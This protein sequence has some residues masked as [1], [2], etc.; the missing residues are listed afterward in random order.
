M[1][2]IVAENLA[3][4]AIRYAGH[5][6]TF[7]LSV[8]RAGE[9]AR[10]DRAPTT[11]SASTSATSPRLFERFYRADAARTS[12]GTGLGLAIVKHI[13]AAAGGE[14][15]ATAARP[16]PPHPLHVPGVNARRCACRAPFGRLSGAAYGVDRLQRLLGRDEHRLRDR[17]EEELR[18]VLRFWPCVSAQKTIFRS[19]A[20]CRRLL[21]DDHVGVGRRSGTRA[22]PT[23]AG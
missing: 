11:A 16:R 7:T 17:R 12:R 20:A 4:N 3:E 9:L 8:A 6:A 15:E 10:P 2:R 21:R 5:G 14:V 18:G 13:V 23:S 22:A 1:L 19:S